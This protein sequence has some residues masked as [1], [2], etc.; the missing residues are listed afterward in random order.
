MLAGSTDNDTSEPDAITSGEKSQS[1]ITVVRSAASGIIRCRIAW[2][3]TRLMNTCG[4]I[5]IAKYFLS[6]SSVSPGSRE[7][8]AEPSTVLEVDGDDVTLLRAGQGSLEGII[9]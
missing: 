1:Q 9:W 6:W 4:L 8:P 5:V 2:S 3:G 7:K